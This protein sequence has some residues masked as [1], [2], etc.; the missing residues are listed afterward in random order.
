MEDGLGNQKR[1]PK[2]IKRL[3][4]F[5]WGLTKRVA[6]FAFSLLVIVLVAL[7]I[8]E[9]M[10]RARMMYVSKNLLLELSNYTCTT[11]KH[12]SYEWHDIVYVNGAPL[13]WPR[14]IEKSGT[15]NQV[16]ERSRLCDLQTEP[17]LS[18]R[19]DNVYL[20]Y[21]EHPFTIFRSRMLFIEKYSICIQHM[22]DFLQGEVSCGRSQTQSR[23]SKDEL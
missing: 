3:R 1:N 23:K 5:L 2:Y 10:R 19:Y 17:V 7:C 9:T 18:D 21:Y 15:M 16:W 13:Y 4:A 22:L 14:V 12:Q 6:T 8:I 11:P 20:S